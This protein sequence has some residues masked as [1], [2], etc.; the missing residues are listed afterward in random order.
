MDGDRVLGL[1]RD[2]AAGLGNPLLARALRD[3]P[4]TAGPLRAQPPARLPVVSCLDA[5]VAAAPA[6]ARP[7]LASLSEARERLAWRQTYTAADLGQAFLDA[8][9]WTEFVGQRGPVASD[10]LACGVL[11]LGP[12]TEYPSHAHEAEEIYIPLSGKARWQRG[13]DPWMTR[14]PLEV[15]HHPGWMPHAMRTEAEPL[16]ALYVWIGG[17]L[18]QKSVIAPR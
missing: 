14:A 8:Y 7:L 3:L 10:V 15:I 6:A 2:L 11:L 18:T 17:N 9:G 16:A 1:V 5:I 13:S 4:A 12:D